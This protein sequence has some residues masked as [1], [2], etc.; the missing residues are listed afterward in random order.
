MLQVSIYGYNIN[1]KNYIERFLN[2]AFRF[3]VLIKRDKREGK[4]ALRK[5]LRKIFLLFRV[6][7]YL[8]HI[9][10]CISTCNYFRY[11]LRKY[12]VF[13]KMVQDQQDYRR[14]MSE[15]L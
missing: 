9:I 5:L 3:K 12:R 11:H 13:K 6:Y 8:L 15:E 10:Y 4:P 2:I 14:L 1:T 7:Y